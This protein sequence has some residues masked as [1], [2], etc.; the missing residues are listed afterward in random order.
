MAEFPKNPQ[1]LTPYPNYRF[2]VK[3]LGRYVA[4]VTK[5][6]GF[7]R[8]TQVIRHR[9]GADA[10]TIRLAP[11]QTE[12]APITM[13]RGVSYDY[14]FLQW[15]NK[16]FDYANSVAKSGMTTS[17][18]DFRRP[19]SVEIYNEA[20]EKVIAYSIYEAWIS[21]FVAGSDLDGLG[22][23]VVIENITIQ[24]QGWDREILPSQKEPSFTLP[25]AS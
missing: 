10:S 2:R 11:G 22:N 4:G 18:G 7:A 25:P 1:R 24:H 5:V 17:L 16:T 23:A 13:E 12:Y 8:T 20:G 14:D 19:L 15:A 9:D 6:S 21:E 3:W